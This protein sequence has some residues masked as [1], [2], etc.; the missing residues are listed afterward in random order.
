MTLRNRTQTRPS[1][2]NPLVQNGIFLVT[3]VNVFA[4]ANKKDR[5]TVNVVTDDG[6][7]F[8]LFFGL[9]LAVENYGNQLISEL[10]N[11]T[12]SSDNLSDLVGKKVYMY[13][14]S[15]N[16][17][18]K[19]TNK[20]SKNYTIKKSVSA[21][22][23]I[24]DLNIIDAMNKVAQNIGDVVLR[25]SAEQVQ[26]AKVNREIEYTVDKVVEAPS[27]YETISYGDEEIPFQ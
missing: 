25:L 19:E 4:V 8:T 21:N 7:T 22:L 2:T 11:V 15:H 16:Y 12:N 20:T 13:V 24:D 14:S 6:F 18:D 5:A 1:L 3:I 10:L 17:T 9:A 27:E 23:T 26:Q